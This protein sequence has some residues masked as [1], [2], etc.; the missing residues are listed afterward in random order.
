[1]H[2]LV[3]VQAAIR[4]HDQAVVKIGRLA[5][6]RQHHAARRDAGQDQGVGAQ[7]PQQDVEVAAGEG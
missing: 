4:E 1:M 2:V 3:G 6:R 5:Q 7:A